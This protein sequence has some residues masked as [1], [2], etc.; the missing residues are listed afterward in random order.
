MLTISNYLLLEY[1]PFKKGGGGGV[2]EILLQ[3][4]LSIKNPNPKP[5]IQNDNI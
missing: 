2:V 4:A 5:S 1:Q 3:V